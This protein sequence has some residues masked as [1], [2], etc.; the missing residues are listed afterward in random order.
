MS[1]LKLIA[2]PF[3]TSLN[4]KF[5]DQFLDSIY[6]CDQTLSILIHKFN[7]WIAHSLALL[8]V[9]TFPWYNLWTKYIWIAMALTREG[10]DWSQEH[11][12]DTLLLTNILGDFDQKYIAQCWKSCPM[13]NKLPN[14]VTVIGIS[15]NGLKNLIIC[16]RAMHQKGCLTFPFCLTE[17]VIKNCLYVIESFTI[18]QSL[19]RL[20]KCGG[21]YSNMPAGQYDQEIIAKCL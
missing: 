18:Q 11:L 14:V 15:I 12:D 21:H 16:Y 10:F 4:N 13:D 1:S 7:L 6:Q 8:F 9:Q 19:K 2:L 3:K 20:M 5:L 17:E